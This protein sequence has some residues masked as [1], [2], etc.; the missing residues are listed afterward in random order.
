MYVCMYV[1]IY[2]YILSASR[3]PSGYFL[4]GFCH[5]HHPT[6]CFMVSVVGCCY[7]FRRGRKHCLFY[8]FRCW[9]CL[10][11]PSWQENVFLWFPC[12]QTILSVTCL[13]PPVRYPSV[14]PFPLP[15]RAPL[16]V[17]CLR[18]ASSPVR[19]LSVPPLSIT[20]PCPPLCVGFYCPRVTQAGLR[21]RNLNSHDQMGRR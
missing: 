9:I 17:T 11:F 10:W 20:C 4:N 3:K 6:L 8:G 16:S 5:R 14:P 13:C 12:L 19:Y 21:F 2:I 18:L 1:Y 15:V 7:G